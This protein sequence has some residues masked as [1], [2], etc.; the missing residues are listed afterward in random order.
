MLHFHTVVSKDPYFLAY[1]WIELVCLRNYVCDVI[2][3]QLKADV[4]SKKKL[5]LYWSTLIFCPHLKDTRG[6]R[7]IHVL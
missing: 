5:G 1:F 4:T 3:K 6:L 2:Y 7:V